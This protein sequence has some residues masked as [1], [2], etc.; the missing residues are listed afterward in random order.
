MRLV[1]SNQLAE[2][3]GIL[4][5]Y[6]PGDEFTIF[7]RSHESVSKQLLPAYPRSVILFKI[8]YAAPIRNGKA[9]MPRK[10]LATSSSSGMLNPNATRAIATA[11]QIMPS[12]KS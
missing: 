8:R 1:S 5:G 11:I 2:S 12:R 3:S 6:H 9:A 10:I 7:A 4:T